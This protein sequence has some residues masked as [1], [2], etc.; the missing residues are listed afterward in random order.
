MPA[1]SNAGLG[2][3]GQDQSYL[4]HTSPLDGIGGA[5]AGMA[6]QKSGL[7]GFLNGLGIK[8][9]QNGQFGYAPPTAQWQ[10]AS[11]GTPIPPPSIQTTNLPPFG[12]PTAGQP[13]A[14]QLP[15]NDTNM[16]HEAFGL[17]TQ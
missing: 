3:W 15:S 10:D 5:L 6:I 8:K 2:Q 13:S 16:V 17:P 11:P 7:E 12:Q 9:G 14:G 1:F 4:Q